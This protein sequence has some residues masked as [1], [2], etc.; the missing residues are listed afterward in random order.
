MRI[1][2]LPHNVDV[3]ESS[4][5]IESDIG[6]VLSEKSEAFAEKKNG[7][8]R[9]DDDG[10]ESVAAEEKLDRLVGRNITRACGVLRGKARRQFGN[11]VHAGRNDAVASV[12]ATTSLV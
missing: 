10:D 1:G 9:E 4:L 3:F 12:G 8:E 11:G 6:Q 2:L 7:D 5:A